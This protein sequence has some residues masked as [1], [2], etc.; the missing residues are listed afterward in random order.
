MLLGTVRRKLTALVGFSAD[1]QT[2]T[3]TLAGGWLAAPTSLQTPAVPSYTALD[4]RV[5][6]RISRRLDASLLVAN[7]LDRRHIEFSGAAAEFRRS[8]LLRLTWTP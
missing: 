7:A 3:S 1:T 2:Q 6:W 5:G 4:A 8:A